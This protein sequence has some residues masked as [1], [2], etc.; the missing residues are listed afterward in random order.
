MSGSREGTL[1][2]RYLA[3]VGRE[4]RRLKTL[5]ERAMAQVGDEEFFHLLGPDENSIAIL[6]KHVAGNM[7]SRWT[8]FTSTDGEKPDRD[9]D[10]EFVV[11][12]GDTRASL[13]ERWESGW[14]T[15]FSAIEPLEAEDLG[16]TI[17]IRGEPHT[18]ME[19]IG[20]Q[21]A[22]YAYHVGQVVFL[23]RHLAGDRWRSLSIPR[24]ESATFDQRP[25]KYLP[26]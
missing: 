9:R 22:H 1:G 6:V 20:R 4:F 25:E 19:A 13:V 15:L 23:A 3:Q 17:T 2:D 8:D 11:E 18:A 21:L 12:K 14:A 24:G 26:S 5:A 7:R 10:S 16:H